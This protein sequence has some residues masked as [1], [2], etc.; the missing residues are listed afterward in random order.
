MS[1]LVVGSV[2]L[3]SVETPFGKVQDALGG[4]ASFFSFAARHYSDVKIVA[5]VGEDFP[6]EYRGLFDGGNIDLSGLQTLPGRTFRW[7]GLYDYNLNTAHTLDT[8]LN[9]F[10]EFHPVLPESHRDTE[11]LFLGNIHPE[12]QREV[13][14]Q[15]KS[16]VLTVLDSMNFWIEREKE[17]L[18]RVM[19]MVDIVLFNEAEA[20][21]YAETP[22]LLEAARRILALGPRSVIIKQ[23]EYGAMMYS[24][25]RE[26][27]MSPAYPLEGVKD[28]TGAGDSFAGGFLGQLAGSG[29]F[30]PAGIRKAM[31]HG[32]VI[33]SFTVEDFSVNRLLS[34]TREEI[35]RRYQE[36][37][38]LTFFE[39]TCKHAVDCQRVEW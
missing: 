22:N 9:V 14:L 36:F 37:R 25:N 10:S 5:V 8:Q 34:V 31:I 3:D 27:F 13:L 12:L 26:I 17:A 2:A 35:E 38:H 4:T 29:D 28:P 30:S 11:L 39:H 20:R 1:V 24:G 32:S 7:S 33:A 23:G 19:E 21:Q 18:T 15:T 6:R 16:P